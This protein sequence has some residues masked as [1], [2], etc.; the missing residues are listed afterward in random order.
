MTG[1]MDKAKQLY[2]LLNKID[3]DKSEVFHSLLLDK[4]K[5]P[6]FYLLNWNE[7]LPQKEL[8]R[9]ALQ[10]LSRRNYKISIDGAEFV[11]LTDHIHETSNETNELSQ[12][13]IISQFLELSP[14]ISKM[15]KVDIEKIDNEI[16]YSYQP[17]DYPVSE[18]FAKILMKQ[19]KYL[20][21]KEVFERLSLKIPEK[22]TYFAS[23]IE[24]LN[25]KITNT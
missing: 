20:L 10:S 21:A 6:F 15:K 19:G 8:S 9:V 24:E 25:L 14:V 23:L 1:K 12:D 4:E 16:D 13:K 7:V 11:N 17:F 2:F 22:K 18:T 3:R 5:Y